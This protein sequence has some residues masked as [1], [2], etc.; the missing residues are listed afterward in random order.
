MA[1]GFRCRDAT[2]AAVLVTLDTHL[3]KVLGFFNTGTADGSI[4]DGNL[5]NGTPFI[6]TLPSDGSSGLVLPTVSVNAQGVSW[7]WANNPAAS[8]RRAV[9]VTYG[10]F[11]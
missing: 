2:T 11:T 7:S 1:E 4:A 8:M 10:F 6:A 3:T 9:D 5:A